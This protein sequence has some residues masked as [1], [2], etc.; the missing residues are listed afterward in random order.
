MIPNNAVLT[1]AIAAVAAVPSL[2]TMVAAAATAATAMTAAVNAYVHHVTVPGQAAPAAVPPG[3]APA[4]NFA[5]AV[6]VFARLRQTPIP[7]APVVA[8]VPPGA[9]PAPA[10]SIHDR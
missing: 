6:S 8:P 9:V 7:P 5:D 4:L 3:P 2:Q 1:G 10:I